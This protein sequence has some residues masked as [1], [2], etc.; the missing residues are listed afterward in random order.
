MDLARVCMCVC[1]C[2][3]VCLEFRL[4]MNISRGK[5]TGSNVFHLFLS[6]SFFSFKFPSPLIFHRRDNI[7]IA[8]RACAESQR[9]KYSWAAVGV[10][11]DNFG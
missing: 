5:L 7:G 11:L 8:E 2:V 1:V 4:G 6:C 10:L 9:W 3:C